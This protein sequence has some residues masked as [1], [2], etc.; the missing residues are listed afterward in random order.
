MTGLNPDS[1]LA[2]LMDAQMQPGRVAWIGLRPERRV[3]MLA[4]EH[5]RLTIEDGLVGD[6]YRSK[7][8]RTRQVTLIGVE[9]L[10]AIRSFMALQV[11]EPERL[12]R[13]L[14]ISGVNLL[15]LKDRRFRVGSAVLEMTGEC[16]P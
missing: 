11:V 14:V 1:P 10:V 9:N 13:N 4:V 7:G 15:A 5:A 2:R 6:R 16:H 8:M 3:P 12:R